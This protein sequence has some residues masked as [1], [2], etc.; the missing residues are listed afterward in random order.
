MNNLDYIKAWQKKAKDKAT[1]DGMLFA[2][3]E[4]ERK[5]EMGDAPQEQ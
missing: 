5:L 1:R 2:E 4:K 3:V